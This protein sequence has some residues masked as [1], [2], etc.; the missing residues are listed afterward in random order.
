[1]TKIKNKPLP[2]KKK[3]KHKQ[4]VVAAAEDVF[5][6]GSDVESD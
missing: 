4:I 1:M 2:K 5:N 6:F 3:Q